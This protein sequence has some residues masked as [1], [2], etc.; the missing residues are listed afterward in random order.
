MVL[1]KLLAVDLGAAV[2]QEG[3]DAGGPRSHALSAF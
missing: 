1:V 2:F 3:G